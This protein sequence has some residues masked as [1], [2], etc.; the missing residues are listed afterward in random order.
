[1]CSTSSQ[2]LVKLFSVRMFCVHCAVTSFYNEGGRSTHNSYFSSSLFNR[3]NL[4]SSMECIATVSTFGVRVRHVCSYQSRFLV[5]V[6]RSWK[7]Q[8]KKWYFLDVDVKC[9]EKVKGEYDWRSSGPEGGI[10]MWS[11]RRMILLVQQRRRRLSVTTTMR[12][13]RRGFWA[14]LLN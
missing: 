13:C 1:M 6:D 10:V 5:L 2:F 7:F 12:V 9:N 3:T 11:A 4:H 8:H 14:L